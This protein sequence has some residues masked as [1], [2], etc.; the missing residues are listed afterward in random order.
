MK[1]PIVL[2]AAFLLIFSS[3]VLKVPADKDSKLK[4]SDKKFS[5]EQSYPITEPANLKIST[6]G[7]NISVL[8]YEGNQVEVSF[9]VTKHGRVLDITLE[10]LKKLAEVEITN[11]K[12]SLAINV[13]K[14]SERN[15]SVG[16][17]IKTPVNTTSNLNTSGGNISIAYLN[18]GQKI[19]TSGGNL[20][21]RNILGEIGASTSGGNISIDNSTGKMNATTS[22]G[23]IS[24]NNLKGEIRTST[25]GGNIH[26][27]NIE[28]LLDVSTSGG[29]IHLNNLSGTVKA[30]TSGGNI[31]ANL[32]KLTVKLELETSGGNIDCTIPQ[33]LGLDLNLSADNIN[34]PLS[35]FTGEAKKN[36]ILGKMNG[37]G[38]PVHLSTSGGSMN[39]NYK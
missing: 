20:D 6:A 33:G 12:S 15:L 26:S 34:T 11:D 35:N 27:E 17:E 16:F 5:F 3:C 39:L 7:G 29:S 1:T 10:E 8:G 36:K 24:L 18:A 19:S 25:S 37:G 31:S 28:G 30:M 32:A 21:I 23:N 9:I 14:I 22:G 13:N 2:F 38:I 4:T